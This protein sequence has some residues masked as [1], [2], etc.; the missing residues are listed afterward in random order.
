MHKY[1]LILLS[2][3]IAFAC[4]PY[5]YILFSSLYTIIFA[6]SNRIEYSVEVRLIIEIANNPTEYKNIINKMIIPL[7]AAITISNQ[8]YTKN[9][10]FF[11]VNFCVVLVSVLSSIVISFIFSSE[12]LTTLSDSDRSIISHF[13]MNS[14]ALFSMYLMM[15]IGLK[16]AN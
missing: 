1:R 12:T 16:T 7:I 13:F 3:L 10:I 4:A 2:S 11:F 14:A 9:S 15:L 5:I 8:V 6:L